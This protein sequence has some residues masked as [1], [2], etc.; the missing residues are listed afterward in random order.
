MTAAWPW[1]L[2]DVQ[3]NVTFDAS[4]LRCIFKHD[5]LALERSRKPELDPSH[6][7]KCLDIFHDFSS[8]WH[9]TKITWNLIK[10]KRITDLLI[11]MRQFHHRRYILI[12]SIF[13]W[14]HIYDFILK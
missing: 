14:R 5:Q 6:C 10:R 13:Q 8:V 7:K 1:I 11:A 2:V 12:Y 9:N 4:L 3:E